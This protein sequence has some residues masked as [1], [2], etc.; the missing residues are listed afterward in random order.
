MSVEAPVEIAATAAAKS[1]HAP[2]ARLVMCANPSLHSACCLSEALLSEKIQVDGIIVLGPFKRGSEDHDALETAEAAFNKATGMGSD[3]ALVAA[4]AAGDFTSIIS[5]LE[6]SGRVVYLH[7]PGDPLT[8]SSNGRNPQL[9]VFSANANDALVE[10]AP[11][12]F[13]AGHNQ[14]GAAG[15]DNDDN[16]PNRFAAVLGALPSCDATVDGWSS[17]NPALIYLETGDRSLEVWAPPGVLLCAFP[18]T[19]RTK[20]TTDLADSGFRGAHVSAAASDG[21]DP[22]NNDGGVINTTTRKPLLSSSGAPGVVGVSLRP[23]WQAG[24]FVVVD[25]DV[26]APGTSAASWAVSGIE[27]V[28]FDVSRFSLL[29]EEI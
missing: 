27:E 18:D 11:S 22:E 20:P 1:N 24:A 15:A 19:T 8:K 21:G 13:V 28:T 7:G 29:P 2:S 26:S 3:P 4:M 6:N 16:G 5:Q 9:T 25:L 12:L 23:L 10:V 17:T 14:T